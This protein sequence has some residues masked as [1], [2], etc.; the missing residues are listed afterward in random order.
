VRVNV[1]ISA[2]PFPE[3]Q[4]PYLGG[5]ADQIADD[6]LGLQTLNLTGVFFGTGY[7]PLLDQEER[8]MGELMRAA[9]NAGVVGELAAVSV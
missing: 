5:S 7:A 1:A 3:D 6:L 4:R 8:R 2:Q 9:R